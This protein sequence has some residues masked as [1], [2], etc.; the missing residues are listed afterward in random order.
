M[1]V[2]DIGAERFEISWMADFIVRILPAKSFSCVNN[3]LPLFGRQGAPQ[4][5][6]PQRHQSSL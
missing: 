2:P 4:S 6:S 5:R 1:T 3:P